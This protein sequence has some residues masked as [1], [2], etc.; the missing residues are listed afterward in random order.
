M[1]LQI[2]SF[3]YLEYQL[4]KDSAINVFIWLENESGKFRQKQRCNTKLTASFVK[5]IWHAVLR[6]SKIKLLYFLLLLKHVTAGHN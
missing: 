6:T 3:L 1:R 5:H 2:F 4:T